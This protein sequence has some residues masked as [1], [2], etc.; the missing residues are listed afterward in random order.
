MFCKT[1]SYSILLL[2]LS[3]QDGGKP[4]I[5]AAW[6]FKLFPTQSTHSQ[7]E[8]IWAYFH[9]WELL[10]QPK[11]LVEG[12][13]FCFFLLWI[14]HSLNGKTFIISIVTYFNR[15]QDFSCWQLSSNVFT[16]Q[17]PFPYVIVFLH[18]NKFHRNHKTDGIYL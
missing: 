16:K 6:D 11:R 13:S 18:N 4:S 15:F 8:S 5:S 14:S 2:G 17:R 3:S 9:T 12:Q 7:Y 1:Q 10:T